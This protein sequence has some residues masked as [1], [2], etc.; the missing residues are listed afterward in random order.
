LLKMR[1]PHVVAQQR[2]IPLS[3]VFN[4]K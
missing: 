3:K 2:G 4:G 1:A